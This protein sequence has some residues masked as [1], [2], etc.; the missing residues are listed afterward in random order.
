MDPIPI[1]DDTNPIACTATAA[2]ISVRLDQVDRMRANLTGIERTPHGVLLHFPDRDDIDAELRQFTVDEQRCCEFWG[3][4][5][6]RDAM[7]PHLR[8]DGPPSVSQF[9]DELVEY[10]QGDEPIAAFSGLL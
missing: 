6:Q 10:F 2:E 5:I 8:W 9:F 7:G 1:Y 4:D 3:F